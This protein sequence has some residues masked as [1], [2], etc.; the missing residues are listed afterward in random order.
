MRR[1]SPHYYV[2]RSTLL[3]KLLQ[4]LAISSPSQ[5][6]ISSPAVDVLPER[7]REQISYHTKT[8]KVIILYVLIFKILEMRREDK[9]L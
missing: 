6:Q 4:P 7:Q 8:G 2:I 9:R 5:I 3:Y 1:P